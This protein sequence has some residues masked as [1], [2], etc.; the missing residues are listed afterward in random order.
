MGSFDEFSS[1]PIEE[2]DYVNTTKLYATWTTLN[3]GAYSNFFAFE[4][5]LVLGLLTGVY[6]NVP[7]LRRCRFFIML[8]LEV[9]ACALGIS[10][11]M[12]FNRD[13]LAVTRIAYSALVLVIAN[14]VVALLDF[15]ARYPRPFHLF[16]LLL[17]NATLWIGCIA[18]TSWYRDG[19]R[20]PSGETYKDLWVFSFITMWGGAMIAI[21]I[22]GTLLYIF[23]NEGAYRPLTTEEQKEAQEVADQQKNL[24][25]SKDT[26]LTTMKGDAVHIHVRGE[27]D[28]NGEKKKKKEKRKRNREKRKRKRKR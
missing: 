8:F 26:E 19:Y 27:E 12:A 18:T 28:L 16:H 3:I 20:Q 6:C 10:G 5:A 17:A 24:R 25:T 22:P 7:Y 14:L 1:L 11:F 13:N 23:Y 2:F 4:C 15:C 9:A 21:P